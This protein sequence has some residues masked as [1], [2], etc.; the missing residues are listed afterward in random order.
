MDAR[1]ERSGGAAELM[2]NGRWMSKPITGTERYA[3]EVTRE[4]LKRDDVRATLLVPK[5][6]TIPPWAAGTPLIRSRLSGVLFEQLALPVLSFGKHLV[7]LSGPAPL[8]KLN[9]SVVLFDASTFR[10]RDTF[11]RAFALWYTILYWTLTR[12]AKRVFT[13]S[14]FSAQEIAEVVHVPESRL[15]VALCGADH[16]SASPSRKPD[17]EVPERFALFVGTLAER[18]NLAPVLRAFARSGIP[19]VVVGAA[20]SS[21]VFSRTSGLGESNAMVTFARRLD[22]EEVYW[23]MENATALVF[24]SLYEGFGLPVVEAQTRGCPVI[25]ADSSSL[26][27]VTGESALRFDPARPEEAVTLFERLETEDGLRSRLVDLGRRNVERFT[28]AAAAATMVD[29]IRVKARRP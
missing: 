7:N 14:Q 25:C 21:R 28:W 16:A 26:P 17:L 8:L 12:T 24:P 4:L 5:D 11:S 13:I 3:A 9:Q 19:A 2:I 6:A 10:Y 1:Q 29:A 23:L 18:K 22:D 27:E 15:T 20:G